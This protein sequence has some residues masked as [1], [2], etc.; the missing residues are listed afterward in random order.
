MRSCVAVM[1]MLAAASAGASAR[2]VIELTDAT[3]DQQVARARAGCGVGWCWVLF[4]LSPRREDANA[5]TVWVCARGHAGS[6]APGRRV[7][8]QGSSSHSLS[9]YIGGFASALLRPATDFRAG[10]A[11]TQGGLLHQGVR[12]MVHTYVT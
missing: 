6:C 10:A 8:R 7:L 4:P 9:L 3:F 11:G 1:L 5:C 12:R 2:S